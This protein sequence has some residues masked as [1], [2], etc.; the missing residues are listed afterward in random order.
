MKMIA[1]S[2]NHLGRLCQSHLLRH[3]DHAMVEQFRAAR[4]AEGVRP[5]TVN[6]DLRH[7]KAA[8]NHAED[9]GLIARNPLRRI[10]MCRE[11]RKPLRI[12]S[13]QDEA[14]LLK[15]CHDPT[16]QTFV[17]TA[18]RTG[19]RSG[20]LLAFRW[21]DVHL[22]TGKVYVR[23]DEDHQTKSDKGRWVTTDDAGCQLLLERNRTSESVHVFRPN[24]VNAAFVQ[25]FIA[26]FNAAVMEAKIERCTIHGGAL[27]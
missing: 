6:K 1:R 12:L 22:Q 13:D 17:H 10:T 9:R 5:A 19:M 3:V 23:S 25:Q 14:A 4:L 27:A 24:I 26:K 20:E 15:A 8:F 16:L 11:T 21:T 18:L 7:L 2:L